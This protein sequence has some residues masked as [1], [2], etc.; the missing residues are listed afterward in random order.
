M[1]APLFIIAMLICLPALAIPNGEYVYEFG[2]GGLYMGREVFRVESYGDT[3]VMQGE[4]SLTQP[5]VANMKMR[6]LLLLPDLEFVSS[7]LITGTGDTLLSV[8][9]NDS[10]L[11]AYRGRYQRDMVFPVKG[12]VVPMDNAIAQH[13]W[14]MA[15][16]HHQFGEETDLEV[17]VSQ[18]QYLGPLAWRE[19][20]N[21]SGFLG[22]ESVEIKKHGFGV[23]GVL[24]EIEMTDDGE[25]M[26]FRVPLQGFEVRRADYRFEKVEQP[27]ESIFEEQEMN[28]LG[29][30]PPLGATLTLPKGDGPFPAVVML[31]GSGPIGRDETV[32]P[33]RVFFDLAQG[34]AERGIASLR[35]DKRTWVYQQT[36]SLPDSILKNMTL[37]EEVIDDAVAAYKLLLEQPGVDKDRCFILGHS[38][39]AMA[40]PI[41]SRELERAEVP[42][43]GLVMLAPPARD[44]LTLMMDQYT[45]L[46]Q[47]GVLSEEK[48]AEYIRFGDR[49]RDAQ[50]GLDETILGSYLPYW[51]S[52]VYLKPIR[53]FQAQ[54]APALLLFA[55]R[56]YQVP[57][58]D[59]ILW[60]DHLEEF[61]REQTRMEVFEDLNHLFIKGE[62]DPGPEE[63]GIRGDIEPDVMNLISEWIE[64]LD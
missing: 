12:K 63:Y 27:V 41:V 62:G 21:G 3:L 36:P 28:V 46:T 2:L 7:V 20:T 55:E 19:T 5:R 10:I 18:Q 43:V 15:Q 29:G 61:P 17:L 59:M 24:S 49:I 47:I 48:L 50:V 40:A 53:N 35:Y 23:T 39:G 33:N 9:H 45:Y 56:D 6:T 1:K 25:M 11:L 44:I 51:D 31:Q 32:G 60:R 54:D 14:L 58:T 64:G 4:T 42:V 8:A 37:D 57:R 26:A 38:L 30:G 52:V 13:L 16:R 22:N 34:L